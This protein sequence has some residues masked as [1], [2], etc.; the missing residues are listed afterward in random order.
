MNIKSYE[1][2]SPNIV[3]LE[4][5][6]HSSEGGVKGFEEDDCQSDNSYL[7]GEVHVMLIACQAHAAQL[8]NVLKETKRASE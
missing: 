4:P 3:E 5:T 7:Q 2:C 1:I 6:M 8:L